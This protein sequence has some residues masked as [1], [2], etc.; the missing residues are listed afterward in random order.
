LLWELGREL[1]QE[2]WCESA[3]RWAVERTTRDMSADGWIQGEGKGCSGFYQMVGLE[4]LG[5]LARASRDEALLDLFGRGF[6]TVAAWCSPDMM[7]A[8]NFGTRS[9]WFKQLKPVPVLVA[10]ALGDSQAARWVREYGRPEWSGDL[11]LW[12]EAL[13]T[14]VVEEE[15]EGPGAV[16]SFASIHSVKVSHGDWTAWWTANP[17]SLWAR[18][19]IGLHHSKAGPV[20]STLHSLETEIEKSKLLIG[21]TGDWAGFPKVTVNSG[22]GSFSSHRDAQTEWETDVGNL[23]ISWRERLLSR[24][25]EA[26]GVMQGEI[27]WNTGG[28][29]LSVDLLEVNPGSGVTLDFH[30]LKRPEQHFGIWEGEHA[31]AVRRGAMPRTSGHFTDVEFDP[32]APGLCGFQIGRSVFFLSWEALPGCTRTVAALAANR[33]LHTGD[34]GGGRLRFEF[35]SWPSHPREKLSFYLEVKP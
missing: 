34:L 4:F 21:D 10:A 7:Y 3:L 32:G 2:G 18:G 5:L 19:W 23:G 1:G 33:G 27:M 24:R 20:F 9:T 17:L 15:R 35:G 29:H 30:F 28:I 25:D 31:E 8:G 22:S 11:S 6:R 26:G 16:R 14:P 12:R 13:A